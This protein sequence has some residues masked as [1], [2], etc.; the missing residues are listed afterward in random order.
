MITALDVK[1]K[2]ERV[3]FIKGIF[4]KQGCSKEYESRHEIL[5]D[6]KREYRQLLKRYRE[7]EEVK[8]YYYQDGNGGVC[9]DIWKELQDV[10]FNGTKEELLAELDEEA[11]AMRAAVNGCGYDCTGKAFM[12]GF[13]VGHIAGNRFKVLVSMALDV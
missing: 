2:L 8:V 13:K 12:T 10:E 9:D 6:A 11:K 7:Q 1:K 3:R 4:R 5:I